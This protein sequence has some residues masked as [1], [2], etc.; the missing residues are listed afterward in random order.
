MPLI[1]YAFQ[2]DAEDRLVDLI[3]EALHS[4]DP[5]DDTNNIL[6]SSCVASGKTKMMAKAMER[7]AEHESNV[8]FIFMTLSKGGL[9]IQALTDL[10]GYGEHAVRFLTVDGL[11]AEATSAGCVPA[12]TCTVIGWDSVNREANKQMKEG[13]IPTFKSVMK[14]NRHQTR[15]VLFVDEAHANL[16][17][18]AQEVRQLIYPYAIVMTTATPRMRK[19]AFTSSPYQ[20]V[21]D[22]ERVAEAGKIKSTVIVNDGGLEGD[23]VLVGTYTWKGLIE[24][25]MK[26][27]DML[28]AEY[29]KAGLDIVP[30]VVIQLPNDISGTKAEKEFDTAANVSEAKRILCDVLGYDRND[31]VLVWTAKEQDPGLGGVRTSNHKALITK[32]AISTGWDCPRAQ[33]LVKLRHAS[34]G[35]ETLDIQTLGRIYRTADPQAWLSNEDY[36]SNKWLNSA[37]VYCDDEDYDPSVAGLRI[38]DPKLL[39]K[40]RPKYQDDLQRISLVRIVAGTKAVMTGTGTD[41]INDIVEMLNDRLPY[42]YADGAG[43]WSVSAD[44]RRVARGEHDVKEMYDE[45][46]ATGEAMTGHDWIDIEDEDIENYVYSKIALTAKLKQHQKEIKTAIKRHAL[47]NLYDGGITF[48]S[49]DDVE[50]YERKITDLCRAIYNSFNQDFV[51][52]IVAILNKHSGFRPDMVYDAHD[53]AHALW[54]P[55]MATFTTTN[56]QSVK[57]NSNYAYDKLGELDS[58]PENKFAKDLF[59]K[60]MDVWFKNGTNSGDSFCIAWTDENGGRRNFFPDFIGIKNRILFIIEVKGDKDIAKDKAIDPAAD[61]GKAIATH[62]WLTSK[63]KAQ[64]LNACRDIDDIVFGIIRKINGDWRFYTGDGSDY[65]NTTSEHWVLFADLV[66]KAGK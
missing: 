37:F 38:Q 56:L 49:Y 63:H 50:L 9:D 31:D 24:A 59:A 7:I 65:E 47:E 16:T 52:S 17:W 25:G 29:R 13:E 28:E 57:E 33:I 5:R 66:R 23:D 8:A 15:I 20:I 58:T 41:I 39:C 40:M 19:K 36:S 3:T 4:S 45:L 10:K 55:P 64:S 32:L 1:N 18:K 14:R 60:K 48:G 22:P 62:K 34:Q 42:G 43:K 2:T 12:N 6:F 51:P 46:A 11:V 44:K 35:S 26:R 27:R 53:A 61:R 30:L 21:V 54:K